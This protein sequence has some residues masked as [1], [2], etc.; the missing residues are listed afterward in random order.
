MLAATRGDDGVH[1]TEKLAGEGRAI[2]TASNAVEYA[3]EGEVQCGVGQPSL[4]TAAIVEGCGQ[5]PPIG[6]GD[7]EVSVDE[8]YDHVYER[9]LEAGRPAQIPLR[10]MH[11]Q[12]RV[13]MAHNPPS[14][15]RAG[16]DEPR[17]SP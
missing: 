16:V 14:A 6:D 3:W 2:L 12:G 17:R 15:H 7:G 13:Y 9:V 10:W 1:L 11:I 4:F 5:A 8:L